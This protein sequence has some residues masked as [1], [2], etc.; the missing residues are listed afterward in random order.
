MAERAAENLSESLAAK[1]D[2]EKE[3]QAGV[4]SPGPSPVLPD[5]RDD[6]RAAAREREAREAEALAKTLFGKMAAKPAA[7]EPAGD[8]D[9][10]HPELEPGVVL[11]SGDEDE[12]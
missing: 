9:E 1:R 2:A 8:E 6:R 7:E 4:T 12:E 5:G 10:A 3:R 11:A